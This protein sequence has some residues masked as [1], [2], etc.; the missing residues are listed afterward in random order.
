MGSSSQLG[1]LLGQLLCQLLCQLVDTPIKRYFIWPNQ[2]IE[3]VA[4]T[5]IDI[6]TVVISARD[7]R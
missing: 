4:P 6:P 1:Q 7:V 3:L 2:M 5:T